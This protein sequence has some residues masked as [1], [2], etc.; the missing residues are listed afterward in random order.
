M[1]LL[2]IFAL[3]QCW[4]LP[5]LLILSFYKDINIKDK[6]ILSV[7]LSLVTNYIIILIL[8]VFNSFNQISIILISSVSLIASFLLYKS[9]IF[10]ILKVKSN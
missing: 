5:G 7:P 10:K 8:L 6:L 3:I 2:G 9:E 4:I 1:F